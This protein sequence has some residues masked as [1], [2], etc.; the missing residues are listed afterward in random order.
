MVSTPD[1]YAAHCRLYLGLV[2]SLFAPPT[3]ALRARLR[4]R[5]IAG[6]RFSD[7]FLASA[8][9]ARAA[10]VGLLAVFAAHGIAPLIEVS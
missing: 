7:A 4:E 9:G 10:T 1:P 2:R 5:P 8:D 6:V 3:D